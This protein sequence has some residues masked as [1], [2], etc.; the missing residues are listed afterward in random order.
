MPGSPLRAATGG[1][2]WAGVTVPSCCMGP[3]ASGR[4]LATHCSVPVSDQR[5]AVVGVRAKAWRAAAFDGWLSSQG[6]DLADVRDAHVDEF[7]RRAYRPRSDC[8]APP[9][10]HEPFAVRQLLGYLRGQGLCAVAPAI[11][12]PADELVANFEQFLLR[13]LALAS[14][15]PSSNPDN[16]AAPCWRRSR[17]I[18]PDSRS[19]PCRTISLLSI[20]PFFSFA[21]ARERTVR[22]KPTKCCRLRGGSWSSGCLA[23]RS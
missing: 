1:P 3:T 13:E 10:R 20:L 8:Q 2:G 14:W 7:I 15:R 11:T 19:R 22:P 18:A 17:A 21:K 5:Y 6:V 12:V 23:A 16:C 4:S 9:R